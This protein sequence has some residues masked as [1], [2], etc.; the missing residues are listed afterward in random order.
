[1][2]KVS[3]KVVVG[4]LKMN[5]SLDFNEKHFNQ[6]KIALKD[7]NTIDIGICVSYPYLFQAQMIFQDSNISWGSQNVAKDHSLGR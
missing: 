6:I 7:V 3:K 5:G 1:M 2:N 4:N